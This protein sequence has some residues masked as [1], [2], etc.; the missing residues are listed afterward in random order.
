MGDAAW[1]LGQQYDWYTNPNDG[2]VS[3]H[4]SQQA[5]IKGMLERHNLEHCT[6]ARSPYQS[7]ICI[8]RIDHNEK[9]ISTK[10]NLIK[11]YQSLIGGLNWLRINT[12]LILTRHIVY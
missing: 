10:I 9:D 6:T 3:C 7:G 4:V 11:E 2:N 5:M 8:N 1:F 12:R